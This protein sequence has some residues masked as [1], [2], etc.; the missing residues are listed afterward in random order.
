MPNW[1]DFQMRLKGSKE[2]IEK[3]YLQIVAEYCYGDGLERNEKHLFRTHSNSGLEFFE[4][5]IGY[6]HGECAWSVWSCMFEG[7][8]TYYSNYCE[9]YENFNGT[10]IDR[11]SREFDLDIEI[12]SVEEGMGFIEN[13]FISKGQ[14]LNSECIDFPCQFN[15]KV[16]ESQ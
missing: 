8:S 11:I 5:G 15:F 10:T 14:I 13:Y 7:P 16:I 6:I 2:N 3:A 9:Q 1:C 4:N 12:C